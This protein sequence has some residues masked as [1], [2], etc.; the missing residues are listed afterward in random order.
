MFDVVVRDV[1][2]YRQS[3]TAPADVDFVQAMISIGYGRELSLLQLSLQ[4][5]REIAYVMAAKGM[6]SW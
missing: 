4:A 1:C 3:R 5:A 6:P 2:F